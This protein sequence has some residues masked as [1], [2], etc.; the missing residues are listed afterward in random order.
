MLRQ[1]NRE[2]SQET[3]DLC[4]N[5]GTEPVVQSSG[6]NLASPPVSPVR[7]ETHHAQLDTLG[8]PVRYDIA[9]GCNVE[10]GT[11]DRDSKTI[12]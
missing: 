6:A 3:G 11:I 12:Q 8:S 7:P 2:G 1:P 9:K 10:T 4:G 5:S